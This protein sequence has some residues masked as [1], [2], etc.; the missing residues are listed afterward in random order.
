MIN[1][2]IKTKIK[3]NQIKSNIRLSTAVSRALLKNQNNF[4]P[5][6]D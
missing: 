1:K 5:K 2:D 6:I 3:E 4:V